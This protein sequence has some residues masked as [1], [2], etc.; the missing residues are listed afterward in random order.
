MPDFPESPRQKIFKARVILGIVICPLI[1]IVLFLMA[2]GEKG[3]AHLAFADVWPAISISLAGVVYF[4][5]YRYFWS[6][7]KPD[8]PSSQDDHDIPPSTH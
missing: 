8:E 6:P 4:W 1:G 5:L 2:I 3:L 7:I